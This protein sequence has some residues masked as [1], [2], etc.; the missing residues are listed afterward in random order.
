MRT[1]PVFAPTESCSQC[2]FQLFDLYAGM[3]FLKV[4]KEFTQKLAEHETC[5]ALLFGLYG[6][7]QSC[8][9]NVL[10]P[11]IIIKKNHF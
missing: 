10:H 7:T 2:T 11:I 4:F 5:V 8:S 9:I 3:D 1:P 6:L